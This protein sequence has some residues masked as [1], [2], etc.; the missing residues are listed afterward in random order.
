MP[1]RNLRDLYRLRGYYPGPLF[2]P[3]TPM[4]GRIPVPVL[5][6]LSFQAIESQRSG[7][8]LGVF[9]VRAW[10][11]IRYSH[12][13]MLHALLDMGLVRRVFLSRGQE[14][15]EWSIRA[16][17]S[18]ARS[19]ARTDTLQGANIGFFDVSKTSEF[20]SSVVVAP[21]ISSMGAP[22]P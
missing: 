14:S 22:V 12:I 19:E 10:E 11:Q 8:P 1:L 7:D 21:R 5:D 2:Y 15:W 3:F 17:Q 4:L 13:S 18:T 20:S 16:L 9:M 6:R